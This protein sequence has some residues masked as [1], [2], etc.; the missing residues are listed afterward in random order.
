[1][2]NL[3]FGIN[4]GSKLEQNT[5]TE[6]YNEVQEWVIPT[7]LLQISNSILLIIRL[8]H[9]RNIPSSAANVEPLLKNSHNFLGILFMLT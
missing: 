3:E 8:H 2:M 5:E 4:F 7:I 9:K 6:K 1:M